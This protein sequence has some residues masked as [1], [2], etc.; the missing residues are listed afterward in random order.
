MPGDS[1][2]EINFFISDDD[3]EEQNADNAIAS[4]D[5]EEAESESSEVVSVASSVKEG[6]PETL[7]SIFSKRDV[8]LAQITSNKNAS[9]FTKTKTE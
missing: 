2:Q 3:E 5:S 9:L 8:T 1:D 6:L 4:G 7:S